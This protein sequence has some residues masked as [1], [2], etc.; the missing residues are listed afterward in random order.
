MSLA[1]NFC[2]SSQVH[3]PIYFFKP[4]SVALYPS[5]SFWYGRRRRSQL[6][7]VRDLIV[8]SSTWASVSCPF[9]N[10]AHSGRPVSSEP[11]MAHLI[12]GRAAEAKE[13]P[14]GVRPTKLKVVV[15]GGGIGGLHVA[16]RLA[17]EGHRVVLCEKNAEVGGR[18]QS[19]VDEA[20]TR[21]D[22]GPSLLL[23]PQ[24]YREAFAAL[25]EDLDEHVQLARVEPAAYRVFFSDAAQP[26]GGRVQMHLDL[27][28]D[29]EAMCRQ[30][31]AGSASAAGKP[32]GGAMQKFGRLM[33]KHDPGPS[34]SF[35]ERDFRSFWDYADLPRLL[36]LLLHLS[37]LELLGQH[38]ARMRGYF[39]DPRLQA[40]FT[41]QDLYVGLSPYDAPGVF[42][43]LAATEITDGV[44]YPLGGFRTVSGALERIARKNGVD[45]TGVELQSGELEEANIVVANADLPYAV[46][47]LLPG[48]EARERGKQLAK[49]KYSAGVIAFNWSLSTRVENIC[50]HNIFMSDEYEASWQRARSAETL[51]KRPNFYLHAPARTDPSAAP[52][53][54]DSIMVLLPVA[55]LGERGGQGRSDGSEAEE[56]AALVAAARSA[57][58]DRLE[59]AGCGKLSDSIVSE[60]VY[61]P[62]VWRDMYNLQH[63]AA[64]GLAH[65][66]DQLAYFRPDVVDPR[67]RGL[68][69]VGASTRPGNGVPLVMMGA[70]TTAERILE[71]VVAW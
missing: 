26:E 70:R 4:A 5:S 59:E 25:G 6:E 43:L 33:E 21:F 1:M 41:F 9:P 28:Y 62:P 23:M 10:V 47:N 15:V 45:A 39:K 24:K 67:V 48:R 68:Y 27:L 3:P 66:L 55:H 58:L 8:K 64:F 35:I 12:R 32:A 50:H 20:G 37:P 22:T 57:V 49:R 69:Y 61:S 63:G 14:S 16:T 30:L 19:V 54:G 51:R 65:G 46:A 38:A 53:G 36:P 17:R 42:S 2:V 11:T 56:E 18:V 34:A 29:V 44:W 7:L 40:L 31:E 71:D 60:L 13:E 52:A